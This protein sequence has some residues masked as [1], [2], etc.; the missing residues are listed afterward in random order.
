[1]DFVSVNR[2]MSGRKPV[3]EAHPIVYYFNKVRLYGK[4][5]S[6]QDKLINRVEPTNRNKSTVAVMNIPGYQENTCT[7]KIT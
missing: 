4:D 6:I 7:D 5:H 3:K 2:R 1:M